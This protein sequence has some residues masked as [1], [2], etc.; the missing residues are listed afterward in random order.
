MIWNS[1]GQGNYNLQVNSYP[2]ELRSGVSL[3]GFFNFTLGIGVAVNNGDVSLGY[4]RLG[5]AYVQGENLFAAL[6]ST[7]NSYLLVNVASNSRINYFSHFLK[8]ALEFNFPYFKLAIEGIYT[9]ESEGI[10]IG[11]RLEF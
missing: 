8:P 3:F 10:T 6:G 2:L 9:R 7:S 4:M 11:M 5:L 1:Y